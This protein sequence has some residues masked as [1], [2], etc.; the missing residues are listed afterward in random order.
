[1]FV[2]EVN[3]RIPLNVMDVYTLLPSRFCSVVKLLVNL[4]SHTYTP[5]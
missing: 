4:T 5:R 2:M 1:M 3:Y